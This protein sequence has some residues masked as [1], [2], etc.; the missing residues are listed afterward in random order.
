[1]RA[2]DV[3][4][5][6]FEGDGRLL[7][8][9]RLDHLARLFGHI[10]HL[11]LVDFRIEFERRPVNLVRQRKYRDVDDEFLGVAD[12]YERVLQGLT[13]RASLQRQ[14]DP[15]WFTPGRGEKGDRGQVVHA[16][17][18]AR[19]HPGNRPGQDAPD[20]ELVVLGG[21]VIRRINDHRILRLAAPAG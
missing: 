11:E 5:N 13:I 7:D 15:G 6:A 19:A 2:E 14:V 18:R 17:N 20:Q 12:I 16:V 21:I 1:L 3:E 4:K 9:W 10:E 8:A